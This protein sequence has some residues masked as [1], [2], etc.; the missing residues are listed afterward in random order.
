MNNLLAAC[1]SLADAIQKWY[2]PIHYI[3]AFI[4]FFLIGMSLFAIRRKT[5][6]RRPVGP[7]LTGIIIGGIMLSFM[8][9]VDMVSMSM[10]NDTPKGLSTEVRGG[11]LE[12]MIRLAVL[13]VMAVGFFQMAKGVV[14]LK[15]NSEGAARFW[16]A[17]TH[18]LG[19]AI[20]VNIKLFM[21]MLGS[22]FGGPL[23]KTISNMLGS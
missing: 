19:G 23:E 13:I 5:E 16:P 22:T 7:A 11:E 17:V 14:M 12:P 3:C 20:C 4:G 21:N 8:S 1:A 2:D 15:Q 10:F 6:D 9:F 18:I